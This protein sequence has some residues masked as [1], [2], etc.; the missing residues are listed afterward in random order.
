MRFTRNMG[1][2]ACAIGFVVFA[3]S[4]TVCRAQCEHAAYAY[5]NRV[6]VMSCN[7]TGAPELQIITLDDARPLKVVG[8]VAVPSDRL[9][10]AA[11]HYKNFLMVARW[12]KFEVY[13]LADLAHPSLAASFDLNKR[14][15]FPG[16]DRIEQTSPNKFIVMT[17]LG[18]VEVTANGNPSEWT[19]E[20][21]PPSKELEKKM[22]GFPPDWRFSDTNQ[23]SVV[24]RET[25]KFRYELVW[26]EKSSPGEIWHR[27]F[28]RKVDVARQQAASE[29]FLGKHLETID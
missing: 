23:K 14:G 25:A 8:R 1:K 13:D 10:D 2:A 12:N 26:R 17:S 24:V 19:I 28:L 29:L 21:I 5:E 11:G 7:K 3:F 4:A 16:Y 20:E 9:F 6:V 27:Q 22:S 15:S 18:A